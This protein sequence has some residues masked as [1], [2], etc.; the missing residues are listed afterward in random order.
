M[1]VATSFL[2]S[3]GRRIFQGEKG[4]YFARKANGDRVYGVKANKRVAVGSD[5][6]PRKI[7]N[8]MRNEVP[9]PIRPAVRKPRANKGVARGPQKVAVR[10]PRANK[11]VARGPQEGALQRRM[12]ANARRM[13]AK[14]AAGPVVRKPRANKGVVRGPQEGA[15]QRRMDA[16]ARRRAAAKARAARR[17]QAM[18]NLKAMGNKNP[19]SALARKPVERKPRVNKGVK[20]GPRK[21]V[22]PVPNKQIAARVSAINEL[23]NAIKTANVVLNNTPKPRRSARLATKSK[24]RASPKVKQVMSRRASAKK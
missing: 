2:N 5:A 14:R 20:R 3:K 21:A 11:G 18:A 16:E 8:S 7:V 23:I 19:Y 13:E 6:T 1:N 24:V 10:K 12:D 22:A 15:L 9:S 4:G 17:R